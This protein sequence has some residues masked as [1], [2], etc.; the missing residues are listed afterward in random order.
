[1]YLAVSCK[2]HTVWSMEFDLMGVFSVSGAT[3]LSPLLSYF[4]FL[5]H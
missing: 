5:L 2:F 4:M 1:M 3:M